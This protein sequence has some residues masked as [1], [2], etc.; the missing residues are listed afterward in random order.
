[1]RIVISLLLVLS[2]TTAFADHG[3]HTWEITHRSVIAVLPTWPG[4]EKPGFGAPNG[5]APEG[6][7]ISI[8]LG[9]ER[10]SDLV[11]TAA[12]V[13]DR[14]TR[15]QVRDS[16]NGILADAKILWIDSDADIALLRTPTSRPALNLTTTSVTP[17]QHV[18]VIANPFGLGMSISCGVVSGTHR[19]GIGFNPIEDFIQTDAAVNPGASGGALVDANGVLVGMIAAIFTKDADIDAGVNFAISSGLLVERIKRVAIP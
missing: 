2:S 18:C 6:S 9:S 3:T 14:A 8:A 1:M 19:G 12:H 11:L 15:V 13:V 17:G 5:V 4:Y 7:G 10:E 16:D